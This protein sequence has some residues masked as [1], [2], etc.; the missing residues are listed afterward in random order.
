MMRTVDDYMAMPYHLGMVLDS[1]GDDDPAWVTW[2][3][4]LPGCISQGDTPDDAA[5]MIREAMALWL[6][7]ALEFGDLIPEPRP[8][9]SASGRLLLRMPAGLHDF[10]DLRARRERVSLNQLVVTLLA[11]ATSWHGEPEPNAAPV[12]IAARR[13]KK[14]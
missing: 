14:A 8:E 1:S 7:T 13:R 12:E 11:G 9:S 3:E 2:V 10:L 5:L 4:E 6:E